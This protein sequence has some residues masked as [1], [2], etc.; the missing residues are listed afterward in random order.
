MANLSKR[1]KMAKPSKRTKKI[2]SIIDKTKVYDLKEAVEVLKQLPHTKFD[3]SVELSFKFNIDPKQ[4][5]AS[6]RGT[7]VLPHGTGKKQRVVVFCKG[8]AVKDAEAAGADLVGSSE[9]IEKV[10][11]GFSDFDIAISTPDMMKEVAKLGKIL[12]PRGL[13]PSPKAGTVPNDVSA[14]IKDVKGGKIEF[15]MDKQANAHV[16]IGKIS[17]EAEKLVENATALIE[18]LLHVKPQGHKG[19]FVR[20]LFISSTMGPGLRLNIGSR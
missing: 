6:V 15:K 8:E 5:G 7:V 2:N 12:G 10:Q 4:S 13:M 14:A 17:F 9:L 11:K 16:L 19:E 18:G 1:T 20:S 3:E